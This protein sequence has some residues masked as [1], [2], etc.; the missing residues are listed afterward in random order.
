MTSLEVYVDV[1][2]RKLDDP[3]TQL[4]HL[5]ALLR[6]MVVIG[7]REGVK[8][9][10]TDERMGKNVHAPDFM[11]LFCGSITGKH[12]WITR[13]LFRAQ[14]DE[15]NLGVMVDIL[16]SL[17][18]GSDIET[19]LLCVSE[20]DTSHS[21][22][23]AL[24]RLRTRGVDVDFNRLHSMLVA[25]NLTACIDHIRPFVDVQTLPDEH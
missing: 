6:Q 21:L 14:K 16:L 8:L 1:V 13:I 12:F 20:E 2:R 7:A 9:L 25:E 24:G 15:Y 3:R 5:W 10:F 11:E 4:H 18:E 22:E 17:K 23:H 19:R